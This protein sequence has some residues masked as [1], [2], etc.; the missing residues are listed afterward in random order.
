MRVQQPS[1]DALARISDR[2]GFDI[3]AERLET[4]RALIGHT[5]GSY[6]RLEELVE[7]GLPVRYPRQPG[8]RPSAADNPLG[9]WSWK[10]DIRGAS[11]G[12]LTGKTVAIKDNV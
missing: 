4:F 8:Q 9:A 10:T 6:A 3:P 7:P 2:Y 12:L 11:S 5:L 1:L